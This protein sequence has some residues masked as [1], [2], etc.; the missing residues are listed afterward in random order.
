MSFETTSL[1]VTKKMTVIDKSLYVQAIP[2]A[3]QNDYKDPDE[4]AEKSKGGTSSFLPLCHL[5]S[6]LL[7]IISHGLCDPS[8]VSDPSI[9]NKSL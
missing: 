8:L 4:M 7:Q 5:F 6:F 3:V 2:S 1:K 9:G